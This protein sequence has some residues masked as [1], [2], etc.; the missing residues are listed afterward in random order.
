VNFAW[1]SLILELVDPVSGAA[2]SYL[3]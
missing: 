1:T 2:A 3:D